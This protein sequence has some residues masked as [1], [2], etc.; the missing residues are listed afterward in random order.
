MAI[1]QLRLLFHHALQ[2][3]KFS[4]WKLLVSVAG[5]ILTCL[6]I[7]TYSST[8]GN[9]G[10]PNSGLSFSGATDKNAESDID[11]E[12]TDTDTDGNKN[13]CFVDL[14]LLRLHADNASTVEYARLNIGVSRTENFTSFDDSLDVAI[15]SYTTI[16]LDTDNARDLR[17]KDDCTT[18]IAIQAPPAE[19][20]PDASH[21]IFGV[22]TSLEKL[23]ESLDAF[24]HW[25]GNTSAH[26]IAVVEQGGSSIR[27]RI[28]QRADDLNL[29]L[30]ITQTEDDRLDR[31]FS[32]IRV[33]Y[34][35]HE[36]SSSEATT[37][38]T[39]KPT[40]WAVLIDDDTFF[41]SMRNLIT[42]LATY[43]ATVPQY[44]GAMTEDLAHLSGSG[45]MAYGGAGIFLSIPLLQDLQH[46]FET[47]QSLKDK[48]DRMLASC[49]YAHTTAKFTWERGLYQLDLH[50][51][52]S[53]FFESGRRLPLSVHHWK[54]WFNADM[55]AMGKVARICGDECLLRRF[56]LAKSKDW[57]LV[58][59]Y[60]VIQDKTLWNE[61]RPME[62]T[63]QKSKYKGD[64][65]FAYSLGPLRRKDDDKVSFSLRDAFVVDMAPE[66]K[67]GT[68]T[69]EVRQIYVFNATAETPPR[70]LEVAWKVVDVDVQE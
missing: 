22:A 8:A 1:H 21:L 49:I 51:D 60:S 50:G 39:T 17:P 53:G 31:Y 30:T 37:S 63:W 35:H 34:Q 12:S 38:T 5:F 40:Q 55:V 59:G 41:P 26:I 56:Y 65:P 23:E 62:Q 69:E 45:Y 32:L 44:I 28:Q 13:A 25:A 9:P 19:P 15:P 43:D 16:H 3:R 7:F 46:H 29:R 18:S 57:F 48:G 70:V 64:D 27:S 24:A 4:S 58:N 14:S 54:S 33:L 66:G 52:A 67:M 6:I 47:C 61:P 36:P 20:K 42:R 2:Q 10:T 68:G 11:S